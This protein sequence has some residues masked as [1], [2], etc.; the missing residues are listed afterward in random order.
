MVPA[1][2]PLKLGRVWGGLSL[3][4]RVY[5]GLVL[6]ALAGSLLSHLAQLN[7]GVI[8]PISALLT[9][10]VGLWTVIR[11]YR[12]FP[13]AWLAILAV[14]AIG[15]TTEVVGVRT[16]R[17]FGHYAYT[18]RWWPTFPIGDGLR[19][20]LQVPFAWVLVVLASFALAT[21][22]MTRWP[23]AIV[24]GMIAALVDLPM[25]PVMTRVL[26]YWTWLQP[27]ALPGGA[28]VENL[29]GWWGTATLG[30]LFLLVAI[31]PKRIE[32]NEPIYVLVGHVAMTLGIGAIS[33][34]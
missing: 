7:P 9:L 2:D 16:G 32:S 29:C 15:L 3:P 10:G 20:P 28:P 27:G 13:R 23:S 34:I 14:F 5:F 8:A 17:P 12:E 6:F 26:G 30:C 24:G 25:E 18:D 11:A 31:Q 22:L 21:R 4:C 19:F 33:L 1:R